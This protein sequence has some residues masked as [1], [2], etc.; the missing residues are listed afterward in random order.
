[1]ASGGHQGSGV[2]VKAQ[3]IAPRA[4]GGDDDGEEMGAVAG[5]VDDLDY[6]L[7]HLAAFDTHPVCRRRAPCRHW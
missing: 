5:R 3:D 6:D 4:F 2:V 7:H 1:M